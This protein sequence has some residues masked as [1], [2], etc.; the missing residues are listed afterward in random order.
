MLKLGPGQPN[1]RGSS[2]TD[3]PNYFAF[4]F[5]VVGLTRL[6]QGIELRASYVLGSHS[7]T[8]L[9]PQSFVSFFIRTLRQTL[10]KLL[11]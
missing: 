11:R 6:V 9:Y 4:L 8:E 7:I 3:M 5:Q 10:K 2:I 1:L